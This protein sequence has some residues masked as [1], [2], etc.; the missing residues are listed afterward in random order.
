[1]RFL[2]LSLLLA[3]TMQTPRPPPRHRPPKA[4]N[5]FDLWV[6]D[7][8]VSWERRRHAGQGDQP[9]VAHPRR[10][11]HQG[12]VRAGSGRPGAAA[13]GTLAER[14]RSQGAVAPGLGDNQGRFFAL[15][16]SA[17]GDKRL[18]STALMA[19]GNEVKGQRMVFHHIAKDA[20]TWDWEGTA[21]EGKTWKLL[22]PLD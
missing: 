21:D 18:F 14:A 16:T 5:L 1:M 11:R 20:F 17:D 19:V 10:Q 13:Q 2:V 8:R 15:T 4:A 6:G 3:A 9:R 12:A 7:W 22:W